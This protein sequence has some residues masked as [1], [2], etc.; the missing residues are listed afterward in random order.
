[1]KC[2]R[3]IVPSA[4]AAVA[5]S[6][7][8]DVAPARAC[9][10]LTP[11]QT[12]PV[13]GHKMIL[14]LGMDQTTLWD[15]FQ[16][17]GDPASFG[18]LLPIKGQVTVGVSSDA[19]FNIFG[20]LTAPNLYAP[21]ICPNSCDS[22]GNGGGA[23]GGGT[24]GGVVTVTAE[25]QVGPFNTVQLASNDAAA[26]QTWL[27]DNGYPV[28]AAVQ[29]VLDAYVAEGFGFL[30]MKLL[31]GVGTEAIQPV[32]VT[33]A[34]AVPSFPMRLLAAGTGDLTQ[35]TLWIV[36]DG[37]YL[38][39]SAPV[40]TIAQSEP[41][42][43]FATNT[44]DYEKLRKDKLAASGGFAY[45]VE[46][47]Q[48]YYNIDFTWPLEGYVDQEYAK[49]GYGATKAEALAALLADEEAMFH[50]YTEQTPFRVTRLTADLSRPALATDLALTA[51]V[52]QGY[53]YKDYYLSK[54]V[55]EGECP[56]DPCGGSGGTGA[57]GAGGATG[58]GATGGTTHNGGGGAAGSSNGGDPID[59][60]T[61]TCDCS[62]PGPSSRDFG[63]LAAGLLALGAALIRRRRSAR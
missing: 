20:Q 49:S 43:D 23:G 56:P 59:G 12:T 34:G 46:S 5:L 4:L 51:P 29:P 63:P 25:Q 14:S 55:N 31:P 57:G 17:T 22:G 54:Y 28:P 45:L 40:V 39:D 52:D 11:D 41:T 1:M 30:A 26:L 21:S 53:V 27:Q 44:S 62:V 16:Y 61:S 10:V 36:A 19:M 3:W 7:F 13:V 37:K 60:G 48:D 8:G 33:M 35:A 24:G 38:P 32:R 42:W 47:S 58:T 50:G 2:S 15:Q 9:A 6:V 18:W